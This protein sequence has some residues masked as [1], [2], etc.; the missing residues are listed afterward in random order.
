[1]T[2][3]IFSK[4]SFVLIIASLASCAKPIDLELSR[5]FQEVEEQFSASKTENDFLRVASLYQ[6]ILDTGCLS[7]AVFYNQGNAY[8]RANQF[9][10]A[11]A[12]YRQAQR[13]R[14]RDPHLHANLNN[15]V[16]ILAIPIVKRS[17]LDHVLFWRPWIS[18]AELMWLTTGLLAATLI[19]LLVVQMN[20]HLVHVRRLG[21]A[22]TV[23]TIIT[24]GSV[25]FDWYQ[26]TRM[27]HG[28]V[29]VETIA[30]KGDSESYAAA[31]N[32]SLQEG[33]EFIV[34]GQRNDWL[35]IQLP[36]TGEGWIL[37]RKTVLY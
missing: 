37:R 8:Y 4:L 22:L 14:P 21:V 16:S 34:L 12:S 19:T 13:I 15:C 10:R 30:R 32:D 31:F 18:F 33:M 26:Y 29:I 27:Q 28:V 6:K 7:G 9:G 3:T 2:T 17:V 5:Q 1:M 35:R 36:R 23:L 11:L 20:P 24:I 25:V